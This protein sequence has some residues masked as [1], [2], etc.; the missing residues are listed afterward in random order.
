M[1]QCTLYKTTFF[2]ICF[3]IVNIY[4][5]KHLVKQYIG[6]IINTNKKDI[7]EYEKRNRTQIASESAF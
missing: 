1:T 5:D 7:N 4:I 6:S 2:I 3:H